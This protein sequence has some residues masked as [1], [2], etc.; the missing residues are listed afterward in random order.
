[1]NFTRVK[2]N[3]RDLNSSRSYVLKAI[4]KSSLKQVSREQSLNEDEE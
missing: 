1:M 4:Q 2:Q 3:Q